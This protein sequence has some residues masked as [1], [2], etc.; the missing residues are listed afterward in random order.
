[1]IVT[2]TKQITVI[3]VIVVTVTAPPQAY[4]GIPLTVSASWDTA[5]GP[6]DG[7]YYWGDGASDLINTTLKSI[8]KTHIYAT[9]G[10]YTVKVIVK[11]R[12]TG[13]QGEKTAPIQI[14]VKLAATLYPS[15]ATGNVPLP[16]S[17]SIGIT[18]GY[19][20]YSWSLDP[21]D[22]S[23]PYSGTRS[24]AGTFTQAH[25]YT[26]VGTFAATLTAT[27]A[28]GATAVTRAAAYAGVAA[29]GVREAA[30][31]IIPLV[32]AFALLRV[33]R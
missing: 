4:E 12:N 2:Q 28:L 1:M 33:K 8:S 17:F 31:I 16:V 21:G 29:P 6:F 18:G 22:G 27:D 9:A 26:K 19:L 13:A 7:V 24:A 14:A 32:A 3:G 25:T 15:P 5:A 20:N 23:S 11:D 10:T 30:A